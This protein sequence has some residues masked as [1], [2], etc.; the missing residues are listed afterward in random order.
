MIKPKQELGL[1][2]LVPIGIAMIV[3]GLIFALAVG[4]HGA[5][6]YLASQGGDKEGL[7]LWPL[8]IGVAILGMVV[9]AAPAL[10]G[11]YLEH[12][13]NQGKGASV[14]REGAHI[15]A[16]MALRRDGSQAFDL[17]LEDPDSLKYL[18][19]IRFPGG[20][21]GEF[22]CHRELYMACGEG[23][24]GTV[25]Y[26]GK[27][28]TSFRPNETQRSYTDSGPSGS[29]WVA[30]DDGG[31]RERVADVKAADWSEPDRSDS[32]LF[33]DGWGDSG[34]DGGG[35]GGGGD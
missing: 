27:W 25:T 6:G 26:Q 21:S 28:L 23:M 1:G 9:L 8:G 24:V 17:D 19:R 3:C 5:I 16:R 2:C 11:L 35:G 15:V 13:G 33:G 12:R 22:L 7:K 18:V 32:G 30:G 29:S 10:I 4:G 31:D 34:G 14:R 20:S